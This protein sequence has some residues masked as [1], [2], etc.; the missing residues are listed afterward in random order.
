M[1]ALEIV[2]LVVGIVVF[3]ISFMVPAGR[4]VKKEDVEVIAKEQVKKAMTAQLGDAKVRI[5]E[6]VE[7]TV[8]YS[9][10]KTERAMER[11]TNEKIAAITEYGETVLK[12]INKNHQETVFLYDM[13][14][15]KQEALAETI[16]EVNDAAKNAASVTKSTR[17]RKPKAKAETE[18]TENVKTDEASVVKTENVSTDVADEKPKAETKD[19]GTESTAKR[20]TT[21]RKTSGRKSTASGT[22]TT[23]KKSVDQQKDA[24]EIQ[25][26]GISNGSD[27]H[28][29]NEKI[30]ALYKDGKSNMA[31]AKELGLGLGEVKLVIDLF[32]GMSE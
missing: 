29:N 9:I 21:T 28:N 6:M 3:V 12:D 27:S 25:F 5:D 23:K 20:K 13:L 1:T 22:R 14:N 17:G 18:K 7:E 15:E 30:L 8:E 16:K 2:L 11:L 24:L 26:E 31:I 19:T 32:K 4:S 10:D